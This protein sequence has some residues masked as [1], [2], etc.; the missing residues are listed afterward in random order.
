MFVASLFLCSVI[1]LCFRVA[2]SLFLRCFVPAFH[3]FVVP[4][5][6]CFLVSLV[7]RCFFVSVSLY[8]FGLM[9]RCVFA[10][11]CVFENLC[12][13]GVSFFSAF[14]LVVVSMSVPCL[15]FVLFLCASLSL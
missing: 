7:F 11:V 8:I 6:L 2:V 12:R 9:L 10:S 14:M 5:F 3:S 13:F 4:L 15:C 1:S